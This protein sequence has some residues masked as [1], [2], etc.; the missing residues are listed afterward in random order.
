MW[1]ST[2]LVASAV[3]L[4]ATHLLSQPIPAGMK[5][6]LASYLQAGYGGLRTDLTE[7]AEMMPEADY[8]FRP[9]ASPEMRTFGQLFAHVAEGQFGTC[10]TV[11]GVP[12]PAAGKNL[13]RALKTKQEFVKALA[14]SFAFCDDAFGTLTD[15]NVLEFV[16]F[17]RGEVARSAVLT[18]ILAHNSEMYGIA[19]VYLRAKN[20]VPPSTKRQMQG[21]PSSPK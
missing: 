20:L 3:A 5:V 4:S 1:K 8:E 9:A 15:A 21:P 12:N 7:A 17:G 10:A 6:G 16:P 18:G 13:E 19:T 11:R 14:D 2:V